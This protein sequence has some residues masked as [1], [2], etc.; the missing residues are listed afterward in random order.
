M[1]QLAQRTEA[2]RSRNVSINTAVWIVIWS[3]PVIRTPSSGLASEYFLRIA[4]KPGISFSAILISL[5]PNSAKV[6]SATLWS[7]VFGV[8]VLLMN[9]ELGDELPE[10]VCFISAFPGQG[11]KIIFPAEMAVVSGF[12]VNRP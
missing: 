6:I 2:P 8:V 12:A 7:A 5:R 11:I 9:C 1:L 3:D 4:I 10:S